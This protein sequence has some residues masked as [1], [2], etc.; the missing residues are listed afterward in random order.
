MHNIIILYGLPCS[1]KSTVI[2][3]LSKNIDCNLINTDD[4]YLQLFQNPSYSVEES[5]NVFEELL[6]QMRFQLSNNV[7]TLIIEGVFA[8]ISR[9]YSIQEIAEQYNYSLKSVFLFNTIENLMILNNK[10]HIE[11]GHYITSE[12]L[13]FLCEKFNSNGFC[14]ISIN[15]SKV[16]IDQTI[17]LI[18]MILPN[19]K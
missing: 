6:S 8:S 18:K 9:L 10:R 4:I 14:D 1:G 2:N 16:S 17:N 3:S 13:T 7:S 19:G 15:T 12:S 5:N 11:G